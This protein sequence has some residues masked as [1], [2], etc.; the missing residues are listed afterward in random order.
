MTLP[1]VDRTIH[2]PARL[3]ILTILS[4]AESVSYNFLRTTLGL[5]N[6][7]LGSHLDR[8]ERAGL[9]EVRKSFQGKTPHTDYA[10]TQPGQT[11]LA[12]YWAALD[13]IRSSAGVGS[14]SP[15]LRAP[16]AKAPKRA[17]GLT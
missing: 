8:L 14:H 4:S 13:A 10:L 6:G 17:L 12:G 5:T 9:V 2:E 1:D 16:K 11:A 3:R 7:N 15:D